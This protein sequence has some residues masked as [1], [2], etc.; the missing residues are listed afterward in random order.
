[1][2]STKKFYLI[3]KFSIIFIHKIYKIEYNKNIENLI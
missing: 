2:D 1:M 3:M